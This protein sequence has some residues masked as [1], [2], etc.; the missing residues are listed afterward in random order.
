MYSNSTTLILIQIGKL[1]LRIFF[2]LRANLNIFSSKL[3]LAVLLVQ[4]GLAWKYQT[5]CTKTSPLQAS[6]SYSS[7]ELGQQSTEL[8]SYNSIVDDFEKNNLELST[9]TTSDTNTEKLLRLK[10]PNTNDVLFIGLTQ[11][12]VSKTKHS[13]TSK[14]G[15]PICQINHDDCLVTVDYLAN[16]CNGLNG[17]DIQLDAQFLHSCKNHSDYLSLAY[18]CVPGA[19]RVDICSNEETF[20]I[21][22]FQSSESN[23]N[24]DLLSS[25]YGSFYLSSPNYPN[26]YTSNLNNC[27]CKFEYVNFDSDSNGSK[28]DEINLV[29]KSYE[30]DL[31]DG[32]SSVQVENAGN[33]NVN[34]ECL[35]DYLR[36][37][38]YQ[39]LE[40]EVPAK[41]LSLCGQYKDFKEFYAR[42]SSFKINFTT[43]DVISRRGF[44]VKISPTAGTFSSGIIIF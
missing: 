31:E 27:S 12:G 40:E 2:R 21:D 38:S 9:K 20:I 36:I 11:Y 24:A 18:E 43:D 35:K 7:V 8:D 3:F 16:E 42:G 14:T 22:P 4:T 17:C 5:K 1:F 34:S 15:Q 33:Q 23:K 13:L 28:Q 25:R 26:E 10:C 32:D 39:R 44:L 29:F 37:D 6:Q 41:S 30:F 19:K